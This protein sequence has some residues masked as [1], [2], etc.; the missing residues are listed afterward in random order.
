MYGIYY[1][2]VYECVRHEVS[3]CA[4]GPAR[5]N[6]V[7]SR[8]P[9]FFSFFGLANPSKNFCGSILVFPGPFLSSPEKLINHF[10]PNV[11][12]NKSVEFHFEIRHYVA[13][14]KSNTRK[15]RE[16]KKM[17]RTCTNNNLSN[18]FTH[19]VSETVLSVFLVWIFAVLCHRKWDSQE[20]IV[21]SSRNRGNQHLEPR[22]WT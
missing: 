4:T 10:R 5:E 11:L 17:L 21:V 20:I 9:P 15:K 19:P 6:E 16:N 22:T 3:W 2:R 14:L 12:L 8:R 18:T 7:W 1:L 13:W